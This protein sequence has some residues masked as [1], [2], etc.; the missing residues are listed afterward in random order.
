MNKRRFEPGKPRWGEPGPQHR[1][2]RSENERRRGTSLA[3]L[4]GNIDNAID[5]NHDTVSRPRAQ[6][7]VIQRP[8]SQYLV[9]AAVAAVI[10]VE[11]GME[12]AR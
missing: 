7:H 5:K 3:A 2:G 4:E 1:G 12:G 6:G 11:P 8:V 10:A 9:S